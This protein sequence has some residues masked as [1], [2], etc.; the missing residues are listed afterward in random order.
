MKLGLD[1]RGRRGHT[2]ITTCSNF[3]FRKRST[4]EGK[5]LGIVGGFYLP[6]YILNVVQHLNYCNIFRSLEPRQITLKIRPPSGVEGR[7]LEDETIGT[8]VTRDLS[9][10]N[11]D[12]YIDVCVK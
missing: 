8:K 3:Y 4:D 10:S 11:L 6:L 12:G 2:K 5:K 1:A 9:L 7:G